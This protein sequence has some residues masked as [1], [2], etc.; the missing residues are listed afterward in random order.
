M[1]PTVLLKDL[2]SQT[3]ITNKIGLINLDYYTVFRN[4]F[5]RSVQQFS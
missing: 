4:I 2:Y 1:V 3:S 5:L